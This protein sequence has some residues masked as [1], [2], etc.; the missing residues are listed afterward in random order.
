MSQQ[1][2][3]LG[4]DNSANGEEQKVPY[5]VILWNQQTQQVGLQFNSD[6]FRTWDFLIAVLDMAKRKAED[7][8]RVQQL[9]AMQQQQVEAMQIEAVKR[10]LGV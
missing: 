1:S 7:H 8:R 10:N 6:D 5:V 4:V 2:K 3:I 9:Q